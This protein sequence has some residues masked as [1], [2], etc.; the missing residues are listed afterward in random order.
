MLQGFYFR[1]DIHLP[2]VCQRPASGRTGERLHSA[3]HGPDSQVLATEGMFLKPRRRVHICA[4]PLFPDVAPLGP[5]PL[6][7]WFVSGLTAGNTISWRPVCRSCCIVLAAAAGPLG[8]NKPSLGMDSQ[9]A[10]AT[11][12]GTVDK[13]RLEVL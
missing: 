2:T 13:T 5:L 9:P 6:V 10:F 4:V 11:W 12:V 8:C 3:L 7:C 1:N